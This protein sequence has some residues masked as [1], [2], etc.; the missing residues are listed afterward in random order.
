MGKG[1][2]ADGSA[3]ASENGLNYGHG[4]SF[5]DKELR[6]GFMFFEIFS[7]VNI[8]MGRFFL[9]FVDFWLD[10]ADKWIWRS[11]PGMITKNIWKLADACIEAGYFPSLVGQRFVLG[12]DVPESGRAILHR[13]EVSFRLFSPCRVW[14]MSGRKCFLLGDSCALP[15]DLSSGVRPPYTG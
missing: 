5:R 2:A 13:A 8:K 12:L 9:F 1:V 11:R 6:T 10:F 14:L 4:F 7:V 3:K 15:G